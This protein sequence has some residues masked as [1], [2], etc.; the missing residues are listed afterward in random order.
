M[1]RPR[2]AKEVKPTR[3]RKLARGECIVCPA[4]AIEGQRRCARCRD[5]HNADAR[6]RVA[7]RPGVL[8]S[9]PTPT[10]VRRSRAQDRDRYRRKI[11]RIKQPHR[12]SVCKRSGHNERRHPEWER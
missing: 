1:Q 4:P 7:R 8:R 11:G 3:A 6:A 9:I 5:K 2:C 12:C 10:A